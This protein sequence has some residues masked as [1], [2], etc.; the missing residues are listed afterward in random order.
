[1]LVCLLIALSP[2]PNVLSIR[3][4]VP[5]T[6]YTL[7]AIQTMPAVTIDWTHHDKKSAAK[8]VPLLDLLK[9]A[10]WTAGPHGKDVK[11]KEKHSG[12]RFV[13]VVTAADGYQA[14][15]SVAELADGKTTAL[16]A[17]AIDG[18]A[19][20]PDL[21]P[22]RLVVT[23]DGSPARSIYQVRSIDLVD[24]RRVVK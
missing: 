20:E 10:G 23:S 8:G 12:S 7:G 21:G 3:G 17:Y 14:V 9:L 15:F 24:M 11:A 13:A 5:S 19:L 2:A 16:L 22:L 1:M 6:G 18:M 4:D